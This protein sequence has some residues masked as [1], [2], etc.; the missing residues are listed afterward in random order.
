MGDACPQNSV[1]SGEI[2][3]LSVSR[4]RTS[5]HWLVT[6]GRQMVSRS[7]DGTTGRFGFSGR[8]WKRTKERCRI[9]A[10]PMKELTWRCQSAAVLLDVT[11]GPGDGEG[12]PGAAFRTTNSLALA[13]GTLHISPNRRTSVEFCTSAYWDRC[14]GTSSATRASQLRRRQEAGVR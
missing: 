3:P 7:S 4:Q 6:V 9:A 10:D 1:T 8:D 2:T 13:R 5:H 14:M 12:L 11:R